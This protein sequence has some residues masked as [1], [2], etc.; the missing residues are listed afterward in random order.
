MVNV[1]L[2]NKETDIQEKGRETSGIKRSAIPTSNR[3]KNMEWLI[4]LILYTYAYTY[5]IYRED[6]KSNQ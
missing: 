5:I 6:G 4:K 3:F 1:K 2:E